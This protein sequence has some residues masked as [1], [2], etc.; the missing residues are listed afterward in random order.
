MS[1]GKKRT[2]MQSLHGKLCVSLYEQF[3]ETVLPIV[4]KTYG[5]YGYDI[6]CGLKKKWNP[7][8]FETAITSF[9]KMC[10]D[11]GM[12]ADVVFEGNAAKV[13]GYSCPFGLENTHF[14]V[15]EA[16]MEMDLEMLK[17]LTGEEGLKMY[18]EKSMAARDPQCKIT[19]RK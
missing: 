1:N 6:G 5:E 4:K 17:V 9:I 12:P 19:Y 3:G 7:E 15:C 16:M 10:N 2:N 14:E 11:A 18:V 8:S 13:T